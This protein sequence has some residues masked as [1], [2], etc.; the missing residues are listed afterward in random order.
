MGGLQVESFTF[1]T[2]F[3]VAPHS[4]TLHICVLDSS[5]PLAFDFRSGVSVYLQICLAGFGVFSR[6]SG[7]V[8]YLTDLFMEFSGLITFDLR[9]RVSFWI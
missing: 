8:S 2:K 9:S 4:N 3:I 7:S 5:G 6:G 1:L